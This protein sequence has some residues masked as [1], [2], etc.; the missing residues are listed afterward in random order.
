MLMDDDRCGCPVLKSKTS[1]EPY[2]IL[3]LFLEL[4]QMKGRH[5]NDLDE[6][7]LESTEI[8]LFLS[9]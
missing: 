8:I 6:L 3:H 2:V 4:N 1:D 7:R 9:N 5:L